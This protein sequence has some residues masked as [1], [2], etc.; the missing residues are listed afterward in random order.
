ML[1]IY[2][3]T[4]VTFLWG[5]ISTPVSIGLAKKFR[6]LD[7]PGGRKHHQHTMPRGAGIVLWSG[8]LLWALFV[9]NRGVEVPYIA[10][11]ST[12]VFIIGYMD[13]M[14]P[15]PPLFRLFFHLAAAAWVAYPLPIVAWQ[16]LLLVV[17]IAGVTNAYN[18]IDGMD[19]LCLL[20]TLL[21]SIAAFYTGNLSVWMPIAGLVFGVFLWNFPNPRTFLGDGGSTFL[22]YICASHLIWTIFPNIFGVNFIKLSFVLL[23]IGGIPVAD[24]LIVMISRLLTKKSPFSPDRGHTHHKL[25]D[26]GFSKITI[27][28]LMGSVHLMII[29]F[30][31][32][33]LQLYL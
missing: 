2:L 10:T 21:T 15:L 7:R 4:L 20:I 9:G 12:L 31:L 13:D 8:Y 14:H 6:L 22:G 1:S 33:I 32:R 25:Q 24:T 5:L 29:S 11:G 28:L 19:G 3:F 30:G 16:R 26:T 27:L 18:L 17:W 23:L